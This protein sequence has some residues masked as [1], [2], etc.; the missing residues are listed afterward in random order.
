M[1]LMLWRFYEK[2]GSIV[3]KETLTLVGRG[4]FVVLF[5][6]FANLPSAPAALT[7]LQACG[8]ARRL[9]QQQ[10]WVVTVVLWKDLYIYSDNISPVITLFYSIYASFGFYHL[11]RG[12]IWLC[13]CQIWLV[14]NFVLWWWAVTLLW[15]FEA[16]LLKNKKA[17]CCSSTY[18]MKAL[19][20]T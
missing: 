18:C 2:R 19:I 16:F 6:F 20:V 10:R 12:N 5:C 3:F 13:S 9:Q 4:F 11:L 17:A 7:G 1:C 8:S 14:T 15:V